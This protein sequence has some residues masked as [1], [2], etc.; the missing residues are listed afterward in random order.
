MKSALNLGFLAGALF[1]VALD[2]GFWFVAPD[3][4]GTATRA[5][6]Q[7]ILGLA[8]AIWLFRRGRTQ[9][10]ALERTGGLGMETTSV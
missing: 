9:E 1:M 2:G 8:G 6:V 3:V 4:E 7:V 10:Q 5:A